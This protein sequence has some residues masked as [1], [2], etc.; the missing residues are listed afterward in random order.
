MYWFS[1]DPITFVISS[2]QRRKFELYEIQKSLQ[3]KEEG[4]GAGQTPLWQHFKCPNVYK[5]VLVLIGIFFFQQITGGYVIIFYAIN[6]FLKIG[7]NFGGHIDEYGAMLLLGV[8]RFIVSL[9]SAS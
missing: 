2:L 6:F 9:I 4:D 1:P 3:R 5:P 8:L 7:G